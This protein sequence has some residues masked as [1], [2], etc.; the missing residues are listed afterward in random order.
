MTLEEAEKWAKDSIIKEPLYHGTLKD[1]AEAIRREGFSFNKIS[2][3]TGNAGML[4]RGFY[5]SPNQSASLKYAK[6]GELLTVRANVKKMMSS[7][8][9]DE[10]AKKRNWWGEYASDVIGGPDKLRKEL[11]ELGY[12]GVYYRRGDYIEMVIF[13]S[14]KITVIK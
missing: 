11:M 14:N 3:R 1:S 10:M 13:D 4:G 12:E 2:S 8:M 6:K 9:F 5:F 7:D